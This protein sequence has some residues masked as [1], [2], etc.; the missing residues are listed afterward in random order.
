MNKYNYRAYEKKYLQSLSSEI[1]QIYDESGKIAFVA[2]DSSFRVT[3][4]LL[5]QIRREEK[6]NFNRGDRQCSGIYY[7]D[8]QGDF[9]IIISGVN[10]RAAGQ[11]RNLLYL[12]GLFFFVGILI[13]YLFNIIVANKTFRPFAALLQKVNATSAEN[14]HNRLP[15][16]PGRKD[17]LTDLAATL[18]IFLERLEK[19]VSN[20]KSFLKNISHELKT[21]LT[22]IIGRAEI[23]LDNPQTDHPQVLQKIIADT[24][25]MQSTIEGLLL[26]SGLQSGNPD[27]TRSRFRLDELVWDTLEKLRFKHPEAVFHTSLEAD[28]EHLGRLEVFATR[29]LLSTALTNVIDNAVKYSRDNTAG[30]VIRT[31]GGRPAI[32]ITDNGPG[33]PEAEM[34]HIFELFFRGSNIRHVPGQGI[35]LSLTRQILSFCNAEISIQ[36]TPEGTQVQLVF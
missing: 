36:S 14:L 24:A 19:E 7:K 20:Q 2:E 25:Q 6:L 16:I 1:I 10:T 29:E 35:G 28:A 23:A 27:V 31:T 4:G 30:I 21:P 15:V 12:L 9:V 8:N 13:N 33:I 5:D 34:E 3:P 11:M 22:A 17:E 18:N 32:L 26:I